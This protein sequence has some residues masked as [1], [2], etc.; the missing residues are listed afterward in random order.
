MTPRTLPLAAALLSAAL[1]AACAAPAP[2]P[3]APIGALPSSAQLEW[4]AAPY[5]AFVHFNMNT[6]TDEEWGD[7]REPA[8]HFAPTALD[9]RQWARVAKEA[10]MSGIILTAKHHDG[11]CLWPSEQ[12]EH[13]VANSSWRDGKGDVLRELSDACREYGLDFGV[14]LSPW[15]R[16]HPDYGSDKYN[17]VFAAQLQE[18]LG[19]YG[20]VWEV[21][22]D[23]ANGEGPNGKRQVYDWGLFHETVFRLQPEA[24][25][26]S[27]GGPGCRW[28]GNER[29]FAGETNWSTLNK[30]QYPPGTGRA[31]ELTS[32]NRNGSHW[33][34]AEA[35]VSIRPGWYYHQSQD[36][37]V[38]SL[39]QLE[40]IW[41][42]SVGR[43]ANLLLN[44]PVDRR[45]I[46]HENDVAALMQLRELLDAT[47]SRN[48]AVNGQVRVS[49]THAPGFDGRH[50]FDGDPATYWAAAADVKAAADEDGGGDAVAVLEFTLH[51][52]ALVDRVMLQEKIALG[53]RCEAFA[54]DLR[55]GDHWKEV[56]DGTTIGAR[57]ILRFAPT[58]TDGVRVR[59]LRSLG[60]PT[61]TELGLYM[62]P[63]EVQIEAEAE[64]FLSM[65]PVKLRCTA[66]GAE[67][68]YTTDG[69]VPTRS[70]E[71]TTGRIIFDSDTRLRARAFLPGIDG[72][73]VAERSFRHWD[74]DD[75]IDAVHVLKEP[76][77]GLAWRAYAGGWQS[78]VD[79]DLTVAADA[80]GTTPNFDLT[81]RP[82]AE[83]CA[84]AWDGFLVA[85]ETGLYEFRI[86]SDDGSRLWLHD[87]LLLDHDGLHG[88][89][90]GM[91]VVI[92]LEKGLHP[93]RTAWFNA[94]GG[95]GLT[96]EWRT[97]GDREFH[98]L[99]SGVLKH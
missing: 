91:T 19:N 78:L 16:N 80:E 64:D 7:G 57:R 29:G 28:V 85:P 63:P 1:M 41:Y 46:V 48:Y 8:D 75:V 52:A 11:F 17:Q 77:A 20:P 51:D 43:N 76:S 34:P 58:R 25:I 27:D 40:E 4:H 23:G 18:V 96:V 36:D 97:P 38:K 12:T 84:L 95:A 26:F 3:P 88:M 24:I 94:G 65:M 93:L 72:I 56:A 79:L 71:R 69:S 9:C 15:D 49:S 22:F 14:Y 44:L 6:F 33:V 10:G 68:R 50:A 35:D 92:G 86:T 89:G 83:H 61:L 5:Y 55:I 47:F 73:K 21:W 31:R 70:S 60:P 39:P 42:G 2:E 90:D 74:R 82:E 66:P 59:F 98:R 53:Q 62:A 87:R 67:I 45:G 99:P 30:D 81:V 37:A 13:S 32:G 54:V